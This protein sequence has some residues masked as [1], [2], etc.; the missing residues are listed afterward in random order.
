M[1]TINTLKNA[2][3]KAIWGDETVHEEPI[4]GKTGDVSR[5]EPY[6]AGNMGSMHT[7]IR[8]CVAMLTL[9]QSISRPQR[10]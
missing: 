4:S 8:W 10:E 6:D 1:E 7:F 3:T 5:G 9:P 2:A